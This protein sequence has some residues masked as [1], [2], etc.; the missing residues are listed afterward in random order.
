MAEEST[1]QQ[2]TGKVQEYMKTNTKLA[3]FFP[4]K[5]TYEFNLQL[6]Q[7][8]TTAPLTTAEWKIRD[9]FEVAEI[10]GK[11]LLVCKQTK[12][13]LL[14]QVTVSCR[15]YRNKDTRR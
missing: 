6:V 3:N 8:T 2:F 1:G 11:Q 14:C 9:K 4:S 13:R 7:K 12:K 15:G 5:A 10:S